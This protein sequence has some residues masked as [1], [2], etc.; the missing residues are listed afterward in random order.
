MT[1]RWI[2]VLAGVGLLLAA[3]GCPQPSATDSP[4]VNRPIRV[5]TL[6]TLGCQRASP[7]RIAEA[8][9]AHRPDIVFLQEARAAQVDE[10]AR[11]LGL[12][13]ATTD[14]LVQPGDHLETAVLAREPLTDV[15]LLRTD[16]R[17]F[18]VSARLRLAGRDL[19]VVSAH[20]TSTHPERVR[21]I[22][23]TMQQRAAEGRLL[24]EAAEG[25]AEPTIIGGDFNDAADSTA[26][27]PLTRRFEHAWDRAGRGSSITYPGF[28][29][30][31]HIDHVFYTRGLE[32]VDGF[33]DP[34][35][36]SD[37]RM[38]VVELTSAPTP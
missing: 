8:I 31:V 27:R 18:A 9:A 14:P 15:A 24:A 19:R 17:A 37:H 4:A 21:R 13:R 22:P 3:G 1:T 35:D 30:G 7:Q 38:L 26:L 16:V 10:L 20:L 29:G 23:W 36:V 5:V 34:A 28:L 11:L 6:N 25:W 32:A 2:L 12:H 33:V